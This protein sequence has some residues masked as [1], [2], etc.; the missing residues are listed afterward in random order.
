[1]KSELPVTLRMVTSCVLSYCVPDSWASWRYKKL[2]CISSKVLC[3]SQAVSQ[4]GAG[5]CVCSWYWRM[6]PFAEEPVCGFCMSPAT[7]TTPELGALHIW[8]S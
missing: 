4:K 2:C 5:M 1:M 8:T 3:A 7:A 6:Q